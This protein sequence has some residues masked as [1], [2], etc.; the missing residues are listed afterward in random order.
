M[1]WVR[2]DDGFA[3]HPK[4]DA[5]TDGAFRLHVAALG[6][7]ARHLT[8]G[9]VPEARLP[10]LVPRYKPAL[11]AELLRE[12]YGPV[13]H[14]PGHDCDRCPQPPPG[15]IAIHDYLE[16]NP[17]ADEER[18]R[19][20]K[21]AEAGRLGGK[22]SGETRKNEALAAANGQASASALASHIGRTPS[23]SP[24]PS[25]PTNGVGTLPPS[26]SSPRPDDDDGTQTLAETWTILAHRDLE[27]RNAETSARGVE[28]ITA[29]ARQRAWLAT[30]EHRCAEA[31]Q[32]IAQRFLASDPTLDPSQLA[33]L[34]DNPIA[35]A[36]A[37][38]P[39]GGTR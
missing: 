38:S 27:R 36:L 39:L 30:A 11:L 13:W 2:L 21:R 31:L 16:K 14:A 4:I 26:S 5:L 23:P 33:D 19:R 37:N 15:H 9:I 8:D 17:T 10:R 35:T 1:G 25:P 12:P 34:L 20:R 7:A 28:P 24:S 18:D 22:R 32:P 3:E 6:H 29:P